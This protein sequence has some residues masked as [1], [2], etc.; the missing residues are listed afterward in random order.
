MGDRPETTE[1]SHFNSTH[2]I[3]IPFGVV[4]FLIFTIQQ[5]ITKKYV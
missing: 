4:N 1:L 3:E 2:L 5:I